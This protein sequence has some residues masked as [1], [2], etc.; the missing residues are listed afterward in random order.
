VSDGG[1]FL[2]VDFGA[3]EDAYT[4]LGRAINQLTSQLEDL[5]RAARPLVATWQG[6]AQEAYNQ[7]QAGW[8]RAADDLRGILTN[9]QRALGDS[10]QEYR[11]TERRNVRRFQ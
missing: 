4:D 1:S 10:L 6:A 11:D 2:K 9:I 3:L 5:D 8:T 7:R